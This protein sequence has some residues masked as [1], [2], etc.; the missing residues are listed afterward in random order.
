MGRC[1]VLKPPE[2]ARFHTDGSVYRHFSY[3]GLSSLLF[4]S[5]LLQL[6]ERVTKSQSL[7]FPM[8]TLGNYILHS[9]KLSDLGLSL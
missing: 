2:W 6:T 8:L 3:R 9:E 5:R 7:L 1:S 4:P